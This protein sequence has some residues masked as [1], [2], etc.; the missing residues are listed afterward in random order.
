MAIRTNVCRSDIVSIL[1]HEMN[2]TGG[3]SMDIVS[4]NTSPIKYCSRCKKRPMAYPESRNHW[5]KECVKEHNKV[6]YD[7]DKR[8]D[9]NLRQNRG[10]SKAEYDLM[11][12]RQGGLCA[13]CGNPEMQI[14]PYTGKIKYLVVDHNH[15]TNEVRELLCQTCNKLLGFIEK[16]RERVKKL[17]KY[18]KKHDT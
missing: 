4:P 13:V 18:L 5:C 17:V 12:F 3:P 1:R 15:Q 8:R 14:D 7:A 10:I 2:L 9:A 16:D 11:F 6:N